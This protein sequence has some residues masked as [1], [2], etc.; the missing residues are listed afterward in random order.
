MLF[1]LVEID[2]DADIYDFRLTWLCESSSLN[3][4]FVFWS[5]PKGPR[6]CSVTVYHLYVFEPLTHLDL[7]AKGNF[8]CSLLLSDVLLIE[9]LIVRPTEFR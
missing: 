5:L 7:E 2:L 1:L 3:L 4:I 8:S 6:S 9:Y